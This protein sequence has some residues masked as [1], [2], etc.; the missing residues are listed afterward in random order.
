MS[1]RGPRKKPYHAALLAQLTV[2]PRT[3]D[4]ARACGLSPRTVQR[5]LAVPSNQT[6]LEASR[7]QVVA[8]VVAELRNYLLGAARTIG[9]MATSEDEPSYVRLDAAA[10]LIGSY[11]AMTEQ[12]TMAARLETLTKMLDEQQAEAVRAGQ[13]P[14]P[15]LAGPHRADDPDDPGDLPPAALSLGMPREGIA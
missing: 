6:E 11:R 1:P 13:M 4:A 14:P 10:K 9:Q 5:W 15:P 8:E 7:G 12:V 2:C 3:E